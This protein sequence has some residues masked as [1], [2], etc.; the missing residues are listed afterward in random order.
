MLEPRIEPI[1][2]KMNRQ[3]IVLYGCEAHICMR[4]TALDAIAKG[5]NV[6]VVVDACSSMNLPDRNVGIQAM[7]DAGAHLTTFQQLIFEL[8]RTTEH[9][10][11]KGFLPLLKDGPPASE[12]LDLIAW[13]PKL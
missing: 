6:H 7:S 3:N 10:E 1:V 2:S 11:F 9:P 8:L 12:A 5:Y 4:Q 13:D